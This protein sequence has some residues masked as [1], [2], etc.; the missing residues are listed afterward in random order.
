[1][2]PLKPPDERPCE[3]ELTRL[4]IRQLTHMPGQWLN[5]HVRRQK[6]DEEAFLN[7]ILDGLEANITGK[8]GRTSKERS[9][10]SWHPCTAQKGVGCTRSNSDL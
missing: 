4:T 10:S 2:S 3:I 6:A 5:E 1:M 7:K 8:G 9:I